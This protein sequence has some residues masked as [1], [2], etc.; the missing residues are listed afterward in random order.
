MYPL[1]ASSPS[2]SLSL[3]LLFYLS[4]LLSHLIG[5]H[6]LMNA[7]RLRQSYYH[8]F[9]FMAGNCKG[10]VD[11]KCVCVYVC[12]N[13]GGMGTYPHTGIVGTCFLFIQACVCVYVCVSCVD[14][15]LILPKPLSQLY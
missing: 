10:V 5:A 2:L 9:I 8:A 15:S 4:L 1:C 3:S 12:V 7:D 6:A 13:V 14:H 11:R